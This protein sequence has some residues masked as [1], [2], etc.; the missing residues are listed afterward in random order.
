[1][2]NNPFKHAFS[3]TNCTYTINHSDNKPPVSG[4]VGTILIVMLS[5]IYLPILFII[6]K[7][8][9]KQVVFF[10]SPYMIIIA[11]IGFYLDVICNVI[12]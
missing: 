3:N 11:G 12:I 6:W 7:W 4:G 2:E 8:R 1:M 5:L 10:K 9:N